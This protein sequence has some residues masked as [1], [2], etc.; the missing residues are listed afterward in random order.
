MTDLLPL[1]LLLAFGAL[2]F[3]LWRRRT[4]DEPLVRVVAG[5]AGAL[6]LYDAINEPSRRYV[7]LL[8]VLLAVLAVVRPGVLVRRVRS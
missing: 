7:G 3:W 8:F 1:V 5:I 4:L 6:L 2:A